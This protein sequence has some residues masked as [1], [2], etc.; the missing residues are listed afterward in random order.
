MAAPPA[1]FRFTV[2]VLSEGMAQPMHL[3]RLDDGRIFFSEIGGKVRLFRPE[4]KTVEEVGTIA[5]TTA[6]ENGLL[7]KTP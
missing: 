7:E 5:V 1:D 3:T 6:N 2:E 4:T